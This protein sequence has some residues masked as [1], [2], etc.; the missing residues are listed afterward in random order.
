MPSDR[1]YEL[2]YIVAP[3]AT[4]AEVEGLHGEIK[5]HIET[6]GGSVESTAVWGRRKLAY[7]IDRYGEGIYVA[8]LING[9]GG[10][11]SEIER[12]LRVRDQVLRHLTVRV[13]E[14]I[15]KARC[16]AEKRRST[17]NRRREARGMAPAPEVTAPAV[18]DVGLPGRP[19]PAT[20]AAPVSD[21][22]V[23]PARSTDAAPVSDAAVE[24]APSTDAAP[25]SDA[26]VEAAPSAE[27]DATI[28]TEDAR[29]TAADVKTLEVEE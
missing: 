28:T 11:V 6:L 19:T 3:V 10:M 25:V 8:Q 20:D 2:I 14:D 4:D 26:A 16:A 22:T 7:P 9:P 29:A 13:D 1:Q 18:W 5:G 27:P 12:R 24:P 15:R 21:A 23:E 17:S